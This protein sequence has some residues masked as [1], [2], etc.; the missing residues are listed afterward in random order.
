MLSLKAQTITSAR[1]M[2]HTTHRLRKTCPPHTKI[3]SVR[4]SRGLMAAA[5]GKDPQDKDS[6]TVERTE[7]TKSGLDDQVP[8]ETDEAFDPKTTDPSEQREGM[9]T[10]RG[11]WNVS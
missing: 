5:P 1:S 7:Y 2:A 4:Q 10:T 11:R 9:G 8:R 6:I 3:A